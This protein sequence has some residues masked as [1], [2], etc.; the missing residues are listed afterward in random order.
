MKRALLTI[1]AAVVA[2]GSFPAH[3]RTCR[4]TTISQDEWSGSAVNRTL[5]R[6][7]DFDGDGQ[8]DSLVVRLSSG[9]GGGGGTAMATLSTGGTQSLAK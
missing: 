1:T 7:E 8:P 5:E 2:I 3:A 4:D 9:S 6:T